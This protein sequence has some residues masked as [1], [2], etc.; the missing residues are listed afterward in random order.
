[1][2]FATGWRNPSNRMPCK[3][4]ILPSTSARSRS[5]P[6]PVG[7]VAPGGPRFAASGRARSSRSRTGSARYSLGGSPADVELLPRLGDLRAGARQLPANSPLAAGAIASGALARFGSDRGHAAERLRQRLQVRYTASEVTLV[8]SGTQ[9]LTLALRSAVRGARTNLVALP[10]FSCYDVAAAAVAAGVRVILYD[11]DPDTLGPDFDSLKI[12]LGEGAGVV[13]AAPLFGVPIDWD[14]I[15]SL[16]DEYGAVVIEDA[17]QGHGA[18]WRGQPLGSLGELSILSFGRGKGWTGGGGAILVRG[19]QRRIPE[20]RREDPVRDEVVSAIRAA[21]QWLLGRPGLFAIA[22]AIPWLHIGETAYREAP[23]PT[24]MD[25]LAAELVL[26]T[27]A[28]ADREGAQ[29]LIQAGDLLERLA[30]HSDVRL[31]RPPAGGKPGY[32]RLPVRIAGGGRSLSPELRRLG[33]ALAYPTT[34]AALPEITSLLMNP[35]ARHTGAEGLVRTLVTLPT[36]SLVT[37]AQRN[38]VLRRLN[39]GS[40]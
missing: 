21:A 5:L 29:R 35:Q 11:L 31:I 36:H 25:G 17:A 18:S 13:V 24:A 6:C 20:V 15:T 3:S 9:A 10:A 37:A 2:P 8:G 30:P 1:M 7:P 23:S 26:K 16:S 27:E 14:V 38:E 19:P 34:L 4:F 40:R 28:A 32:L 12:A 33:V 39:T 22:V